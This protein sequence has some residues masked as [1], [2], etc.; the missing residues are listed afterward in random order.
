MENDEI[1][2]IMNE[3]MEEVARKSVQEVANET[4]LATRTRT[5]VQSMSNQKE[6]PSQAEERTEKAEH[7]HGVRKT[8]RKY[9]GSQTLAIK[10]KPRLTEE[11]KK[12]EIEEGGDEDNEME[13]IK[14]PEES[15][16]AANSETD[17]KDEI[18]N[19]SSQVVGSFLYK[20]LVSLPNLTSWLQGIIEIR[21]AKEY[22]CKSNKAYRQRNIWGNDTYTSD[23]DIVCALQHTSIYPINDIPPDKIAGVSVYC[24]V[25]K[26]KN[27]YQSTIRN[28]IR[29]RKSGPFEGCSIKLENYKTLDSLGTHEELIEMAKAMPQTTPQSFKKGVPIN[30]SRVIVPPET[31]IVFNLSSEPAYK[32]SLPAFADYGCNVTQRTANILFENCLYFETRERRYEISKDPNKDDSYNLSEVIEP[33][34]KDG[35]FMRSHAVPLKKEYTMPVVDGVGWKSFQ[36]AEDCSLH[37]KDL[38]IKNIHNFKYFPFK[39][40]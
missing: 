10:R 4:G 38:V 29:S 24:R 39:N 9:K 40:N 20:P 22:L 15:E 32:F 2:K 23:T 33:F 8:I 5:R 27:N 17:K 3:V 7:S 14:D 31:E 37:V 6:M 13:D 35:N 16:E 21:V 25:T 36:W 28:G 30:A 11:D 34:E 18:R 26:G 12:Q 19:L 1:K